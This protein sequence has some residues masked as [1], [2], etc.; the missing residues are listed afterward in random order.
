MCT[1]TFVFLLTLF[2]PLVLYDY[3]YAESEGML[4]SWHDLYRVLFVGLAELL[5]VS[6]GCRDPW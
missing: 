3:I 2:H 6:I 5:G 1:C 4:L